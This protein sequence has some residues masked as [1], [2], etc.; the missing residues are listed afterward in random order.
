MFGNGKK[1]YFFG[2][3]IIIFIS[4]SVCLLLIPI[5]IST[6]LPWLTILSS[7]F[8]MISILLSLYQIRHKLRCW[9][10]CWYRKKAFYAFTLLLAFSLLAFIFAFN[11]S[12]DDRTIKTE[13]VL[14]RYTDTGFVYWIRVDCEFYSPDAFTTDKSFYL[15]EF[16]ISFP[17]LSDV[18]FMDYYLVIYVGDQEYI[19]YGE[20]NAEG[21]V[22]ITDIEYPF[23]I[24]SEGEYYPYVIVEYDLF[25]SNT[26]IYIAEAGISDFVNG[27]ATKPITI[28]S[29]FSYVIQRYGLAIGLFGIILFSIPSCITNLN[30]LFE[31]KP[32][33]GKEINDIPE[34]GKS[35]P[36]DSSQ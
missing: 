31:E 26:G 4:I 16:N 12:R 29:D 14:D 8:L 5:L 11:I 35:K 15:T 20:I 18:N 23:E 21:Y 10:R 3:I 25:S 22:H 19:N 36:P 1:D 17:P 28:N 30:K 9:L 33:N 27:T 6:Q 13:F 24:S 7:I 2:V 32:E 34:D